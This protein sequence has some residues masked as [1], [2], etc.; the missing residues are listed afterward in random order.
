MTRNQFLS[1][2]FPIIPYSKFTRNPSTQ[3]SEAILVT[4]DNIILKF[5]W[6][7]S[8]PVG[9]K[10][11][12]D[13]GTVDVEITDTSK[14]QRDWSTRLHS[15]VKTLPSKL[16]TECFNTAFGKSKL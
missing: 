14:H 6:D 13:I 15:S 12:N 3:F 9:T 7:N 8:N 1:T 5:F 4:V 11:G 16:L 10:T 2:E